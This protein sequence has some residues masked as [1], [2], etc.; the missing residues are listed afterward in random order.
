MPK[1]TYTV[2][3]SLKDTGTT[4]INGKTEFQHFLYWYENIAKSGTVPCNLK[5]IITK[6][7]TKQYKVKVKGW[8][9][10]RHKEISLELTET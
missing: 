5:D 8:N 7:D 9:G 6:S 2:N 4:K 3:L 1:K 10:Q